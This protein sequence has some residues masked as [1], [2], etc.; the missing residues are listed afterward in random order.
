MWTC[1]AGYWTDRWKAV[2]QSPQSGILQE[3]AVTAKECGRG[4]RLRPRSLDPLAT[5]R[6]LPGFEVSQLL[7]KLMGL[8]GLGHWHDCA[9]PFLLCF[10]ARKNRAVRNVRSQ[11][12]QGE[13]KILKEW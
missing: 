4:G 12:W 9:V 3:V 6:E 10:G 11:M 1:L 13:K 7:L 2:P 5:A 8:V